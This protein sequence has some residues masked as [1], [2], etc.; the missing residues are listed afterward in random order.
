MCTRQLKRAAANLKRPGA[1]GRAPLSSAQ[2]QA[3]RRENL[4]G[5]HRQLSTGEPTKKKQTTA[6]A[7]PGNALTTVPAADRASRAA[8][9]AVR[10]GG[11]HGGSHPAATS[12]GPAQHSPP[13]G[14]TRRPRFVRGRP[15]AT[16][17][18]DPAGRRGG[19]GDP[20]PHPYTPGRLPPGAPLPQQ[21][22][23]GA[24]DAAVTAEVLQRPLHQLHV[25]RHLE[26]APPRL[27]PFALQPGAAPPRPPRA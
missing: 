14:G 26:A 23:Q 3:G 9:R 6:P 4:P 13:S 7:C 2:A 19:S 5:Q 15:A 11:A 20:P 18:G 21:L 27:P 1:N 8:S 17:Q 22:P 16:R 24:A 25:L 10:R 12:S